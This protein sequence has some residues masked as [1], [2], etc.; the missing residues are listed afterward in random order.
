MF[1]RRLIYTMMKYNGNQSALL[2]VGVK[3]F[4]LCGDDRTITHI[5]MNFAGSLRRISRLC[6]CCRMDKILHLCV[7]PQI[8][9]SYF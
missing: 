7:Q 8:L 2:I 1:I 3:E 6:C 4:S 9:Y 5:H